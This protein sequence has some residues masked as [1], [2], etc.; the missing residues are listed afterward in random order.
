MGPLII[1][2][3][4]AY[5]VKKWAP[6]LEILK[7]KGVEY[8]ML[9]IPGLTA[10][11]E[12]VWTLD[13]YVSWL[14]SVVS[15]QRSI[16]LLGHSNGGRISLA[17]V[18]KYPQKIS[19]LIL[20]DSAGIYHQDIFIQIKRFIFGKFA[21]LKRFVNGNFLQGLFYKIVREYDYYKA[22]PIMKK[23]LQNLLESDKNSALD[24]IKVPTT[25]I[26]GENDNITPL[27]DG[28]VMNE[29]IENSSLFTIK[30][31]G[32]SPQFTHPKEVSR[33]VIQ[34]LDNETIG[35]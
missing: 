10:S 19:H 24:E 27:L 30:D 25:L 3:G 13:D 15:G 12:D 4:W 5:D 28:R 18:R 32:H 16:V 29:K 26:W 22:S 1:L 14:K 17:Y 21:R 31:A 33:I 8:K 6:F 9:K 20:I 7:E 2:H 11:L 23:V 35:Q 34:Q